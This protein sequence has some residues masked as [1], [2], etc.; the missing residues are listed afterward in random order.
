MVAVIRRKYLGGAAA[1]LGGLLAAAC[2]EPTVR[3]V[4]QPQAGPA[5]PA[6]PQGAKGVTGAQGAQGA[7]GAAGIAAKKPP[8]IT[9][10]H[11]IAPPHRFGLADQAVVK[12]FKEN[13]P[14]GALVDIPTENS[15]GAGM[16]KI[17]S[18]LAADTPP[19]V[20]TPWQVEAADL[21]ALGATVDLN[22]ALRT[23]TDWAKTKGEMIEFLLNGVQW[24]GQQILMPMFP[25]P[26]GLGFN[27][28]ILKEEGIDFPEEGYTWDDFD[29][30]G[31]A[32]VTR[33]G[34]AVTRTLWSMRYSLYWTVIVLGPMN[35][36]FPRDPA[37]TK[38]QVDTPGMLESLEYVYKHHRELG[39]AQTD[40][41]K[42]GKYYFNN[43][44]KVTEVINPGTVTPPRYPD[45][46]PGDGSV[47][48]VTHYPHGPANTKKQITTPGNCFGCV[49]FKVGDQ[50]AQE[51]SADLAAWS[52]REDVQLLVSAA[53]GHPPANLAAGRNP[54]INAALRDNPILHQLNHL[55]Q[56]DVPTPAAPSMAKMLFEIGGEVFKRLENG[57]LTP[58]TALEESQRLTAPLYEE[59]LK[60]G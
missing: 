60:R 33:D 18:F 55:A 10:W 9:F 43:K 50:D 30:I 22:A 25:D 45:V 35:G 21:F 41:G 11:R 1:A 59:D 49:V 46:D 52:V 13:H 37:G 51:V 53:S 3:Y 57:E 7:Q 14:R 44:A 12:H 48:R 5:G 58:K 39:Y 24:K 2:G 4:G 38:W 42:D 34:G 28:S 20:W 32:T 8:E 16:D 29:E 6:G 17:K 27:T 15:G 54:G 40:I 31:K 47:I 26:H 56:Y 23:N 19:N 36:A